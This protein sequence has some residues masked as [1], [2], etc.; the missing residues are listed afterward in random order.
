MNKVLVLMFLQLVTNMSFAA[1]GSNKVDENVL[2]IT[3][4][5]L[6]LPESNKS[7]VT[8]CP[9]AI[10]V[11]AGDSSREF[12]LYQFDYTNSG[13]YCKYEGGSPVEKVKIYNGKLEVT[14]E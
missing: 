1:A 8:D 14:L 6:K 10:I 3:N 12:A 11:E 7:E 5:Y 4:G 9:K 2:R 13:R